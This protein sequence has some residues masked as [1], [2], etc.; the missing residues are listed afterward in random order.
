[1]HQAQAVWPLLH[2]K[3]KEML[4][5]KRNPVTVATFDRRFCQNLG[6][7][8]IPKYIAKKTKNNTTLQIKEIQ[9]KMMHF[10]LFE[11][12]CCFFRFCAIYFGVCIFRGFWHNHLPKVA[13]VTRFGCRRSIFPEFRHNRIEKV[14]TVTRFPDASSF[15]FDRLELTLPGGRFFSSTRQLHAPS[16]DFLRHRTSAWQMLTLPH[17]KRTHR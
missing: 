14:A 7:T 8:H 12:L 5:P 2:Q 6:K 17:P 11:A 15:S 9:Q 4:L 13:T 16:V 1:M 10:L 3:H